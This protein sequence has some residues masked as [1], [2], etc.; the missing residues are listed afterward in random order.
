MLKTA[1]LQ[2]SLWNS[3][4]VSLI[5]GAF[6]EKIALKQGEANGMFSYSH[7]WDKNH[8]CH[9]ALPRE[10]RHGRYPLITSGS[11]NG[12]FRRAQEGIGRVGI[13]LSCGE[14]AYIPRIDVSVGEWLFNGEK[15]KR[16]ELCAW[17]RKE[18]KSFLNY[19]PLHTS[20]PLLGSGVLR[21]CS[22]QTS[23][24]LHED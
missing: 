21:Y 18:R 16:G 20:V 4:E 8:P 9:L 19:V 10:A 15:L 17:E 14:R 2:G 6:R 11:Q 1:L 23:W 7:Q 5:L 13:S 22:P 12:W 24:L 3:G